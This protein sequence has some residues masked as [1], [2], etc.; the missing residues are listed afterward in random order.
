MSGSIGTAYF[1][2]APNMSGVQGK[3]AGGLRGSGSQFAQQFGGEISGKSAFIIGAV[4]GIASAASQ[5]LASLISGSFGDAV[6]RVDT[7]AQFPKVLQAM[8]VGS[9]EAKAATDKLSRSLQGLP[10]GL[11]EGASGVQQFIAAGLDAN[12]ATDAYLAMNDALL[13]GGSNAQDTQIV[14]ESLTRALSGGST[15]ATTIQ[16]ALSRMPT[17]LQGLERQ[18]GKTAGELYKFYAA[19]PKQLADDLINLDKNGGGGLASLAEQAKQATGG[20]GTSFKNMQN[21]ISRGLASIIQS[22]GQTNISA[23][24]SGIGTAF[25]KVLT[26]IAK[27][28]A[29]L[30]KSGAALP[31]FIGGFTAFGVAVIASMIASSAAV[32]VFIASLAAAAIAALPFLAIGAVIGAAAF[33]ITKNW[34]KIA[35]VVDRVKAAFGNFWEATKPVRDFIANQLKSAFDSLVKIGGQVGTALKPLID[36]LK[37]ILANKTVQTVLKVIGVALLAI[38]AAPIVAFFGIMIA[39]IT[40][41][42][43]VLGFLANHF[44]VIKVIA[45]V[46]FSPFIAAIAIA[47]LSVKLIIATVKLLAAVFTTVFNAI[48]TVVTTAFSVISTVWNSV[49]AP[50]LNVMLTI[51]Q[52]IFGIYIKVWAAIALVVVGTMFIIGG[53]IAN[54]MQAIW[55]VISS[56]WNA[57]YG[58]ISSVIGFITGVITNAWNFYYGIISS[59]LSAIWGVITSVWNSVS[60]FIGGVLGTIGG[61]IGGAWDWIF[62]RVSTGLQ[63]IWNAVTGVFNSVVSFVGGIG[64]KIVGAIGNFGSLL[65]DKGK[66]LV[67]GLLDGAG[68]LLSKVG[69][70]FLD[71]L[72]GWIQ[73]PFKKALGISSPSKIFAGYG[74]NIAEGLVNGINSRAG[75]VTKA[76]SDMADKAMGGFGVN[77]LTPAAVA[78]ATPA[79]SAAYSTLGNGTPAHG[80]KGNTIIQNNTVN[81]NVDLQKVIN[82]MTWELNRS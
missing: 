68:S 21:A 53:I 16:A 29:F 39:S 15:Q 70:F 10:T 46:I 7:L 34:D 60:G 32:G 47:I 51:I 25:E 71:K 28:I 40:V 79:N 45:A 11:A 44:T 5:K 81:T 30:D 23:A 2:V 80:G 42:S 4:A 24:I 65:Y 59:V 52:T 74:G 41:L 54:V 17:A 3:I 73:G 66:D 50:V 33:L 57:I 31:I 43:K 63:N 1:S 64:G 13:A 12:K 76:V 58:V 37:G 20:I 82:D 38:V 6:S 26:G 62:N 75:S 77:G 67:Q 22:V 9:D 14:M 49:L 48:K 36:G 27:F 35:P 72:P 61:I 78:V 69:K 19:N 55:G 56:V 8:G 18:T